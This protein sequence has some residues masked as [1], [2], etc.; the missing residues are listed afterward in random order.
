MV[1]MLL[2]AGATIDSQNSD[3]HTALML[4]GYGGHS[5]LGTRLLDARAAFG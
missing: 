3:G 5:A 1:D 4:A 2:D